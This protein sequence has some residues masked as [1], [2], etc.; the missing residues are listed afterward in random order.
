MKYKKIYGT[1]QYN[2]Y[3]E[4]HEELT[5]SD[6]KK[7]KEEVELLEIL[8]DEYERRENE[9]EEGMDPV[10]LLTYILKEEGI[11]QSQLAREL[12]ISRQLVT[13]IMSY[14]R[15]ISKSVALKLARRFNMQ[16]Q[17][18]SRPYPLATGLPKKKE[19]LT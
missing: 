9:Y 16:L 19:R 17:A 14:R 3:C 2:S 15:D 11:S 18:F 5:L 4:I 1:D 6:Y 8:I 10:E 12:H 13:D 7:H